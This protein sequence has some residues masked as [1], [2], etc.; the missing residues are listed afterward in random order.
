MTRADVQRM[1]DDTGVGL[2]ERLF[3][4]LVHYSLCTE[5]AAINRHIDEWHLG[6]SSARAAELYGSVFDACW[7]DSLELL[8]Q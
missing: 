5:A 1:I 8:N 4:A 6:M 3:Q 2:A 7:F